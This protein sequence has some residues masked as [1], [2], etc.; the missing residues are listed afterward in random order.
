MAIRKNRRVKTELNDNTWLS[1]FRQI[2]DVETL[3]ELV[4]LGSLLT[5]ITLIETGEDNIVWTRN[6]AGALLKTLIIYSEDVISQIRSGN[7][8]QR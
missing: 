2:T 6:A 1:S 8:S 3:H 5:Q 4:Q 7:Q